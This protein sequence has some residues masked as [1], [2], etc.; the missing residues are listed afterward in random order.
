MTETTDRVAV[1]SDDAAASPARDRRNRWKAAF[2]SLLVLSV[3]ST[4]AWVLFGSRLLVVRHV[5]VTG[6][7]LVPQSRVLTAAGVQVGGPMIR[8]DTGAVADRV[9]GIPEVESV[10]VIRKWPTTLRI[11]VRERVPVVVVQRAGRFYQVDRYG[12]VVRATSA[13]PRGLPRLLVTTPGPGDP[14]TAAALGVW[15]SLPPRFTTRLSAVAAPDPEA[16]TLRL[17]SG[18]TVVWGAPERAV[19]KLRLVDALLSGS[20]GQTARTIDVSSTEVVTTR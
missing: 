17:K 18:V 12:V 4:S 5:E 8:L 9:A 19:E 2:V 20:S 10:N 11:I 3:L 7:H 13:A 14:A 16:V 15:R 6:T 1:E